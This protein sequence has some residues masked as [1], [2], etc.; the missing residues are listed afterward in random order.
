[1]APEVSVVVGSLTLAPP[2]AGVQPLLAV[3]SATG[4]IAV[5]T[6]GILVLCAR[7]V[8]ECQSTS[9]PAVNGRMVVHA[10]YK[11][12][13]R[14]VLLKWV[15]RV[16]ADVSSLLAV[17]SNGSS[18]LVDDSSGTDS[19]APSPSKRVRLNPAHGLPSSQSRPRKLQSRPVNDLQLL[20]LPRLGKVEVAHVTAGGLLLCCDSQPPQLAPWPL[21]ATT[22]GGTLASEAA[23]KSGEDPEDTHHVLM[24]AR[25]VRACD[26]TNEAWDHRPAHTEVKGPVHPLQPA[27]FHAIASGKHEATLLLDERGTLRCLFRDRTFRTVTALCEAPVELLL[28]QSPASAVPPVATAVD[29]AP[30]ATRSFDSV[31]LV[32]QHGRLLLLTAAPDGGLCYQMW[33]QPV[34]AVL[35]A[36]ALQ[37]QLV[38]LTVEGVHLIDLPP[39]SQHDARAAAAARSLILAAESTDVGRWP[40][41]LGSERER[42]VGG[43]A[44]LICGLRSQLL[45]VSGACMCVSPISLPAGL[46]GPGRSEA[47]MAL[48]SASGSLLV[49]QLRQAG[50]GASAGSAAGAC[51]LGVSLA[52]GPQLT[53]SAAISAGSDYTASFNELA[54]SPCPVPPPNAIRA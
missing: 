37:R 39:V 50:A 14:A 12:P 36:C 3:D 19:T 33:Q 31:V 5:S 18:W 42:G 13:S 7:L 17:G 43:P 22:S 48:C 35:A 9:A 16:S 51:P 8:P 20:S 29:R 32:G 28:L 15:N 47:G 2:L 38:L 41:L 23:V 49:V 24:V 4:T 54:V 46:Q 44:P 1:M 25:P 34:D 40:L 52:A 45:S 53:R 11:L 26:V 6:C 21:L 30:P 27:L 10:I